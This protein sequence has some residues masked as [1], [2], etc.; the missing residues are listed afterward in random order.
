M[1]HLILCPEYPP[2]PIP[3]GGIGRYVVHIAH[4]LAEAGETV[5][6]IGPLWEGAPKRVEESCD[7]RLIIHRVSAE[8]PLPDLVKRVGGRG[9]SSPMCSDYPPQGFAWEAGLL[10]EVLVEEAGIDVIESQ[11]HNAPLYFFQLRRALGLGPKQHPPC[12]VHLHSPTEFIVRHNEW[13]LGYSFFRTA[14]RLEDFSIAAADVRLCPSQYL[15]RQAEK[16]Y[17][18]EP[19]SVEVIRLPTGD[20]QRIERDQQIWSS[21]TI[22]YT[23]RLEP[24]K[25]IIEWVPAAVRAAEDFSSAEFEF[26]GADL[27]YTKGCSVRQWVER[28]IPKHLKPRFH[29]RGSRSRAELMQ[30]LRGARLAAVPSRWENFPNTCIEAMSSGLP[31]ISTRNGGMVEMID[32]GKTGWLAATA[33]SA[34]LE[35]AL[36]RALSTPPSELAVMG[37]EAAEA[38]QRLCDNREILDRHLDF[39][40]RVARS[41]SNGS[42]RLPVNLP[43][44]G[45]PLSDAAGRRTPKDLR[46]QGTAI[47]VNCLDDSAALDG[48]LLAIQRQTRAPLSVV[49]VI[50]DAHRYQKAT[51]ALGKAHAAGWAICKL[52][53]ASLA[54][55]R[56]AG[57]ET[58]L[59]TPGVT[60]LAF[61][62]LDAED[63]LDPH[64]IETCESVILHCPEVGL[65]SSWM[66]Y[67]GLGYRPIVNPCPAFPYQLITDDIVPATMIRTEALHEVGLF[68][69]E[70]DSG[71][72]R[73][74]LGNA[75]MALGWVAVTVP[76]LLSERMP[77]TNGSLPVVPPAHSRMRWAV[78]A[79]FPE[80]VARDVR[81]FP[82]L[83]GSCILHLA[84]HINQ[85]S[86]R[87]AEASARNL[88][89]RDI[90]LGLTLQQQM[91]LARKALRHP[92][93]AIRFLRLHTQVAAKQARGRL[94]HILRFN[95]R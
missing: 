29:F 19:G 13:D 66:R 24:R 37:R 2:A 22:C 78:L 20:T 53:T 43:W 17:G 61:V 83:L 74:D 28:Q 6:V 33:D 49:I 4:L 39:R 36:R 50:A 15:A 16:H 5:H 76:A 26:I 9:L 31:V 55:S 11:E 82:W 10:A 38:V 56:N 59:S 75:I 7:G 41:G 47:V 58:L 92:R 87:W 94:F 69:S 68:R 34:G 21:G 60:P 79:R 48:C 14:K 90:L 44:A 71:F 42:M 54:D 1:N 8:A 65:V 45:R 25:G 86:I 80:I 73:W 91:A 51:D 67:A 62:F 52:P 84:S 93:A 64:F 88:R 3:P 63:R 72:E 57:V 70:L 95:P 30:L 85:R 27:P 12:I 23:G 89:P 35:A 46:N 81:D 32:D 77:T 40:S 18:L